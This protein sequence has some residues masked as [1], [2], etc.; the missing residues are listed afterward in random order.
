MLQNREQDLI[1][2]LAQHTKALGRK[3]TR[4][5]TYVGLCVLHMQGTEAPRC[6]VRFYP[7]G[8]PSLSSP[9]SSSPKPRRWQTCA[10]R[11]KTQVSSTFRKYFRPVPQ[12]MGTNTRQWQ[13]R[14]TAPSSRQVSCVAVNSSPPR[15]ASESRPHQNYRRSLFMVTH[16]ECIPSI[17][18]LQSCL[19]LSMLLH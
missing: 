16:L 15:P 8:I 7:A 13:L 11:L 12:L 17:H 3:K 5:H 18:S 14:R 4:L 9:L 1:M 10:S 19:L 2:S 6:P